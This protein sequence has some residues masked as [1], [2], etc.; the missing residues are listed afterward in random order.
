MQNPSILKRLAAVALLAASCLG[1]AL[2]AWAE[3]YRLG[4]QDKVRIKVVDWQ[5][6]EKQ[7]YEW[8][9]LTGDYSVGA[10]GA[11]SLPLIGNV[12]ARGKT[13]GELATAISDLVKTRANLL[14]Q[15]STS[16]EVVQFRPIYVLGDVDKPGE[17]SYRPDLS[18]LQAVSIAGGFF[19]PPDVANMRL[20]RDTINAQGDLDNANLD[21]RR[22]LARKARLEAEQA[23]A[24]TIAVPD[25]LKGSPDGPALIAAEQTIMAARR[26]QLK[27]Q[28]TAIAGLKDLYTKEIA[29]LD[30]KKTAEDQQLDNAMR[31]LKSISGL[32]N[33][34]LALSSR[35]FAL[36]SSVSDAQAAV[37]D[38]ATQRIRA[39]Q[40]M[41]KAERE[42]ID[43]Q[44][45]RKT[46]IEGSLRDT[47]A[48]IEQDAAKIATA[49]GLIQ[50]A[51]ATGRSDATQQISAPPTYTIVRAA[52]GH[53]SRL[54]ADEGTAVQPGD[55]VRVTI[56]MPLP[57]ASSGAAIPQ[58][59]QPADTQGA[60]SQTQ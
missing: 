26:D 29:S 32:V 9:E 45:S 28:L 51:I 18:V 14:I 13:P 27:A 36:Q 57:G 10:D 17:Y 7:L 1:A 39:Q 56:P 15:P 46:E 43:L 30:E 40:E 16:V 31:E 35:Q 22:M 37:V 25:A 58:A 48:A 34:G 6:G 2:P 11:I 3:D 41:S 33:Q 19:R 21:L 12:P 60:P 8:I 44:Q 59:G 4:A 23:G 24:T 54:Q 53:T 47:A 49:R 50:E 55:V 20:G 52:D 42:G 5:A 38:N